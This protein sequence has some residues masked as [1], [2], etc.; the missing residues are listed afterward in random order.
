MPRT[1]IGS[2]DRNGRN[3]RL[4]IAVLLTG[5]CAVSCAS[6]AGPTSIV[7]LPH[8]VLL[9]AYADG[10]VGD[11]SIKCSIGF[12]LILEPTDSGYR[13]SMGGG[14]ERQVLPAEGNGIGFFGDA[15]YPEI[16]VTVA[17]RHR[18]V[19]VSSLQNGIVP[20]PTGESRFW[21]QLLT[22]RGTYDPMTGSIV[23]DWTCAPLDVRG[24]DKGTVVGW[25]TLATAGSPSTFKPQ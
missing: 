7:Q 21:D 1:R 9:N 10:V 8:Q 20:M 19:T 6:P 22:F 15:Y 11:L 16:R 13:G 25:W 24:D 23:G 12:L 17:R 18:A 3:R 14:I 2:A 4:C 5:G